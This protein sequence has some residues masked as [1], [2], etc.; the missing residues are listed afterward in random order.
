MSDAPRLV[1]N[2]ESR[3]NG[4]AQAFSTF[5]AVVLVMIALGFAFR[6]MEPGVLR[7][8]LQLIV[9]GTVMVAVFYGLPQLTRHEQP[10][11]LKRQWFDL[12][13]GLAVILVGAGLLLR[14]LLPSLAMLVAQARRSEPEAP[15]DQPVAATSPPPPI[16]GAAL[17]SEANPAQRSGSP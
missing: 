8:A 16:D 7:S 3:D 1:R 5:A 17:Q 14:D 12:R 10:P 2:T 15:K 13:F 6:W 11:T 9:Q 4:I